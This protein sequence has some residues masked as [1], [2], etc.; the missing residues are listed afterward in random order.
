MVWKRTPDTSRSLKA[1][2]ATPLYVSFST[3]LASCS[4]KAARDHVSPGSDQTVPGP[5]RTSQ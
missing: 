1:K 4:G 5:T 2:V 3:E